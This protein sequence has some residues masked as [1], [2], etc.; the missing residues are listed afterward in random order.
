MALPLKTAS[1]L[2]IIP[3]ETLIDRSETL[4]SSQ[5]IEPVILRDDRSL[6]E[7]GTRNFSEQ[8]P[9]VTFTITSGAALSPARDYPR[10]PIYLELVLLFILILL[11]AAICTL[12]A[13]PRNM[14][15]LII[16]TDCIFI[17]AVAAGYAHLWLPGIPALAATLSAFLFSYGKNIVAK[18]R[19]LFLAPQPLNFQ[20]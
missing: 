7:S 19:A 14:A 15:F 10:I 6:A 2:P 17:Q 1:P 18:F 9:A 13:S 16:A 12:P 8:L 5:A 4:F 20:P 3:A 11:L